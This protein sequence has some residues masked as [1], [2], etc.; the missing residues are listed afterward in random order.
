MFSLFCGFPQGHNGNSAVQHQT[1]ICYLMPASL[2]KQELGALLVSVPPPPYCMVTKHADRQSKSR[3]PGLCSCLWRLTSAPDKISQP[4]PQQF[5]R[6]HTG[7]SV[8]KLSNWH[9]DFCMFFLHAATISALQQEHKDTQRNHPS[10]LHEVR[11]RTQG[12][13]GCLTPLHI[14]DYTLEKRRQFNF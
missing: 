4:C 3:Q 5:L 1:L 9:V 14:L 12:G 6:A 2:K 13:R 8:C 7:L 10:A 11:V